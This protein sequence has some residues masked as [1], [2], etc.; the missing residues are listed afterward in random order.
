MNS[1]ETRHW[2]HLDAVAADAE[3]ALRRKVSLGFLRWEDT[4]DRNFDG[5]SPED[6]EALA[7]QVKERIA[8]E[9][10]RK[11]IGAELWELGC[12]MVRN[13]KP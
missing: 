13:F 4:Q 12:G 5:L 10:S 2:R 9:Q 6:L 3:T 11:P 7:L 1:P 8:Y